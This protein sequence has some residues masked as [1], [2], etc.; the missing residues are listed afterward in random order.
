[1]RALRVLGWL[2]LGA[3]ALAGVLVSALLAFAMVPGGR[4][5]VARQAISVLDDALAGRFELS[6][7]AVLPDGGVEIAGLYVFD[8]DEHLVLAVDRARV[9][10][11]LTRVAVRE[12]GLSVELTAPSF[13]LEEE[14]DGALSLARAFAPARPRPGASEERDRG[15]GRRT[16]GGWT[17]RVDR[18]A[19]SRGDVW[20]VDEAGESRLELRDLS[21]RA[22]AVAGPGAARVEATLR[23][24]ADVPLSGP[25][26][27]D[28]AAGQEGSRLE[29]PL[30][31]ARVGA[32]VL[33]AAGEGDLAARTGRAAISRLGVDPETVAALAPGARLPQD[34]GAT[35]YAES[36]G[37]VV[38]AA[39]RAAPAGG[40]RADVA[41]A[42]RLAAPEGERELALGL[43]AVLEALDPSAVSALLPAGRL[44]LA[45]RGAAAGGSLDDLRGDLDLDLARSTLR[46]GEAGPGRLVARGGPGEV[47]VEAL[48]LRAPGLSAEGSGRWRRDGAVS[49]RLALDAADLGAAVRNLGALLGEA[50]PPAAG[51]LRAA[52]DLS[53]SGAAPALAGTI[54]APALR[55]GGIALRGVELR[56]Q[57]RGPL[58][59]AEG[60]VRGRIDAVDEAGASA[61]PPPLARGVALGASLSGAGAVLSLRGVLP[62]LGEDPVALEGRGRFGPGR[63]TL[64]LEELA[65]GW[66]G[67]RWALAAPATVTLAGPSVDR[68]AL[69]SGRQRLAL[70]GGVGGT[71][72]RPAID[73]TLEATALDLASLPR[74]LLPADLGLAGVVDARVRA[75]GARARP[76]VQGNFALA[77][78]AARGLSGLA[79]EGE[80]AWDGDARRATLRA[81]LAREG[82]GAVEAA[83]ELPLPLARAAP[84][85]TLLLEV[86]GRALP[87]ADVAAA[88]RVELPASGTLGFR[89]ALSGTAGAPRLE[90]EAEVVNGTFRETGPLALRAR[91]AAEGSEA[92]LH[93]DASHEPAGDAA[94]D[95]ALPLDLAALIVRPGPVL[96]RLP[97]APLRAKL[98][99]PGLALAPLAGQL[100]IPR[101][102]AG[103][104]KAG[105]EVDG[106]L[107]APRARGTV[108]L[109]GGAFRGYEEVD[110]AL[111]LDAGAERVRLSGTGALRGREALR[112][113]AALAAAP[114]RLL[115]AARAD[116]PAAALGGVPVSVALDVPRVA[117]EQARVADLPLAGEVAGTLRAQGTLGAPRVELDASGERLAVSGRPLGALTLSARSDAGRFD[118]SGTLR[119]AAGGTVAVKGSAALALGLAALARG[120]LAARAAEAPASVALEADAL[121]LGVLPALAPRVVR[122][123]SGTLRAKLAGEG[124]LARIR[125]DGELAIE[126]GRLAVSEYGDWTG[127]EL[128]ARLDRDD[129]LVPRLAARRG[130]GTLEASGAVRGLRTGR[131]RLEARAQT[132]ALTIVRA[133]MDFATLDL[134][135]SLEGAVLPDARR[136]E[137]TLT[138]PRGEIRLPER[139]PRA[140]QPLERRKDIAVLTPE[141]ARRLRPGAGLAGEGEDAPLVEE[142]EEAAWTS[143]VRLV[144]PSRLFVR[145]RRP[146]TD[147]EL[148]ADATFEVVGTEPYAEGQIE[149]IRGKVSPLAD[150]PFQVERGRVQFTGGPPA[151]ALLDVRARYDNPRAV[152]TVLI[153]GPVTDPEIRL[154]SRPPL[155]DAEIALLIAT[156]RT[157][158]K[159]GTGGV[160][161]LTGQEAGQAVLGTLVTQGFKELLADKLPLDSVALETGALRAG[162]YVTDKIYVGYV[163]RFEARREEGE[164]QDEVRVEYQITPR[165]TFES[166]YGDANTGGAR[167][168]WSR[169]Y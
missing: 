165:W 101:G 6:G 97:R 14:A 133:G 5:I 7:V 104:V 24:V 3:V 58:R 43:V 95:A 168:L 30:L 120:D 16:G 92:A 51:R 65:V 153:A 136:L 38:T 72:R 35:A 2:G 56:L 130:G 48:S 15:A 112:L 18:L 129:V 107:D 89:A 146:E 114:E 74:G 52:V 28:V 31:A 141:Q 157:E 122:S 8:P 87:L 108:A 103:T 166:R 151:A 70:S 163:R 78:G 79:L 149:V 124:P 158:L 27:L 36:D 75:T 137:A 20:W 60:E 116:D 115:A 147:L 32:S 154:S 102:V 33:R 96:E 161:T 139:I 39:V 143:V 126:R 57:A 69:A 111:A 159:A 50:L 82:G 110:L 86:T 93:L 144:V 83:L 99:V 150:R 135:A 164:N 76:S 156:G 91:L 66:P 54:D 84:G 113:E 145:S 88:A 47:R 118:A 62:A 17:V 21:L 123:A 148:K 41:A 46:G 23:G 77:R 19:V 22:R 162:K 45:A 169:D 138:V 42:A 140:L 67:A 98:A 117:L 13:L 125:P 128:A 160:G 132:K 64:A 71:A 81:A 4:A 11:D 155:D 53:G 55:A 94:L 61:R 142:P 127:I 121:D 109:A 152:V 105:L 100:G 73:A 131:A 90:A 49:G 63:E 44:T 80:G 134:E 10:V 29:V 59:S 9:A 119:A 37:Q 1:M 85:A 167:L 106:S 68:L 26:E 12:V 40:G 25:V 34:L